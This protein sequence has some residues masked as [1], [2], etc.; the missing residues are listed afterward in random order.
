MVSVASSPRLVRVVAGALAAALTLGGCSVDLDPDPT[1]TVAPTE[2]TFGPD[3]IAVGILLDR[4][5]EAWAEVDGWS[6]EA[7]TEQ[8]D[9]SES[10]G[11]STITTEE[12]LL[13]STRRVLSTTAETVVSEEIA[14][15]GMIYMRGTRVSGSIFP[16]VD[17]DTWIAFAP[18][19]APANTPLAQRVRYLTADPTFPFRDVTAGTRALPAT[20]VDEAQLDGRGCSVYQFASAEG[21]SAGITY[22]IAFDADWLPCRLTLEAGGIVETTTWSFDAGAIEITAPDDAVAVDTFPTG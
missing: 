2:I 11:A 8:V 10:G 22:R 17:A 1:P 9:A 12:V 14:I 3:D 6:S 7:R 21:S 15:G 19:A 5:R 20:P 18:D 13:P 16:D 4:S